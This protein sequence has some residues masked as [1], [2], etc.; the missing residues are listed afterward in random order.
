[1]NTYFVNLKVDEL[2]LQ[3]L[4]NFTAQVYDQEVCT[5]LSVERAE[6]DE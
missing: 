1:M 4:Q 5:W 6:A 3:A 2:W